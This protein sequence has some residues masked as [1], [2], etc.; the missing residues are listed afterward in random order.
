MNQKT[1]TLLAGLALMA[2]GVIAYLM[3][4]P[5]PT[6]AELPAPAPVAAAP[7][8]PAASAPEPDPEIVA[9][10]NEPVPDATVTLP[11]LGEAGPV[12][13]DLLTGLVGK[14]GVLSMLQTDGFLQRVVATVDNLTR[15]HAPARMW[16]VNPTPGEFSV[17]AAGRIAPDNPARYR[18]FVRFVE[19]VDPAAA[20]ALYRRLY[21]LLQQAYQELG[22]PNRRFHGRLLAVIDHLLATP[23]REGSLAVTLTEVKGPISPERPW[24]RFEFA[25]PQ[26]QSLSSGQKIMLRIGDEHRRRL[27]DWLRRFRAQIER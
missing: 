16:P 13:K 17:D 24:V 2:V 14:Q 8:A 9:S 25:D 22:Y 11:S 19:G 15:P 10:A 26:L 4:R 1:F 21:P 6:P 18:A 3:F 27:T 5:E 7:S 12:V 23:P 20:A